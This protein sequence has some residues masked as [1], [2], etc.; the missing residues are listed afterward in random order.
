[1]AAEIS[2]FD[3]I[4]A[5]VEPLA[6]SGV[7]VFG[8]SYLLTIGVGLTLFRACETILQLGICLSIAPFTSS[9]IWP[10][11]S[12][13]VLVE[14]ESGGASDL[15]GVSF[16]TVVEHIADNGVRMGK[17]SISSWAKLVW[18]WRLE[19]SSVAAVHVEGLVALVDL[20]DEGI[21]H[22]TIRADLLYSYALL[23]LEEFVALPSV[24]VLAVFVWAFEGLAVGR[25]DDKNKNNEAP[26]FNVLTA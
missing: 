16:D 10:D 25:R 7:G 14:V 13:G 23:A 8:V 12:A 11:T 9:R 17:E 2:G 26:H 18:F 24:R 19:F 6:V 22:E 5:H 1:M 3:T 20:A 15:S 4:E 21:E